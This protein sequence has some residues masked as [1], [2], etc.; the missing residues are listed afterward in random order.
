MFT[1]RTVKCK[2]R[3]GKLDAGKDAEK[4]EVEHAERLERLDSL[5]SGA[6]RRRRRATVARDLRTSG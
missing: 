5:L 6:N 1:L 3:E 4:K 2:E